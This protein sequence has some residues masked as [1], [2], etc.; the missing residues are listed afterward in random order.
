V[1]DS[2]STQSKRQSAKRPA[3]PAEEAQD[4]EATGTEDP[5]TADAPVTIPVSQLIEQGSPLL[6]YDSH[7]VAGALYGR[8]ADEELTTDV[9]KTEVENWLQRPVQVDPAYADEEE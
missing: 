4:V 8:D 5:G 9:A 3:E 7:V 1:A 2:E 6:G